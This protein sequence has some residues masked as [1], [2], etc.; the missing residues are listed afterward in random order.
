MELPEGFIDENHPNKVYRL[1]KS[2]YGLKQSARCWNSAI[3]KFLKDNGYTQSDADPC[4]YSKSADV[5]GK[6]YIMLIAVY[7]DD[8]LL[9]SNNA[10]MMKEEKLKLSAQF[11]MEDQSEV[12]YCLGMSIKRDREKKVL[13]IDQKV[14]LEGVLKRFKMSDCKPV[15]TPLEAGK[16][17]RQVRRRR[18]N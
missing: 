14:Y 8:V 10:E 9:A 3:D 11:E 1:Q 18:G 7:V 4:I 15:S 16:K 2:I 17:I 12:H 13:S 5:D 6:K